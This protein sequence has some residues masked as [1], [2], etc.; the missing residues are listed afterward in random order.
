MSQRHEGRIRLAL[1]SVS[2]STGNNRVSLGGPAGAH[3]GFRLRVPL[4]AQEVLRHTQKPQRRTTRAIRVLRILAV[5]P[6]VCP[7]LVGLWWQ[8]TRLFS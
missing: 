5:F 7:V 2:H 8:I 6:R 3:D 1:S 4:V